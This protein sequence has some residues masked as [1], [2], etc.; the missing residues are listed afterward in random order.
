MTAAINHLAEQGTVERTTDAS[1][2]RRNVVSLTEAGVAHLEA[3]ERLI[4]AAQDELLAPLSEAGRS[5]LVRMLSVLVEH[6]VRVGEASS[7]HDA[8]QTARFHGG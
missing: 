7:F 3:M 1:D 5:E 8:D 2:R 4:A 6:H